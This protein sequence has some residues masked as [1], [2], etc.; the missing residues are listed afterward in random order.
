M[1]PMTLDLTRLRLALVG[2]GDAALRRLERLDAAGARSLVVFAPQPAAAFRALAGRRLV[3]RMPTTDE[4]ARAQIVFVAGLAAVDAG[5]IAQ[6]ARMAGSV[7][8][9][10]DMP[11]I[12]D[13]QMPA[14]LHRGD[15]TIAVSTGGRSPA[16]AAEIKRTLDRLI[17]PEWS[18][19]LERAAAARHRWRAAGFDPATVAKR[20]TAWLAA[21]GWLAS[22]T[23]LE[24]HW[25]P[26]AAADDRAAA[27]SVN[28]ETRP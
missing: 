6:S 14:T 21:R 2:A 24:S 26:G 25:V 17:G 11:E 23:L 19:R 4:L 1:L 12:S 10:E 18:A 27:A 28:A 20:T 15:L 8:H 9:V 5:A 16:L 3:A 13:V 22:D 7:V